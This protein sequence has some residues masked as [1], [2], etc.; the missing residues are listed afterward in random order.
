MYIPEVEPP[1]DFGK[2]TNWE[3]VLIGPGWPKMEPTGRTLK[4]FLPEDD[5]RRFHD[6][7]DWDERSGYENPDDIVGVGCELHNSNE[8]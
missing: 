3:E 1:E 8:D 6:G 5:G 7:S 2:P 4:D